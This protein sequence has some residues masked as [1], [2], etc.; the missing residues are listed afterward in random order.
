MWRIFVRP[1]T[2]LRVS[3]FVAT[4]ATAPFGVVDTET[5]AIG[6]TPAKAEEFYTRKRV[7]GRWI[8]GHFTRRHIAKS[9]RGVEPEARPVADRRFETEPVPTT[10]ASKAEPATERAIKP[11]PVFPAATA[12]VGR[13]A[14]SAEPAAPL[15]KDERLRELQEALHA[16]ARSLVANAESASAAPSVNGSL[17]RHQLSAASSEPKSVSFEFESGV[18]TTVFTDG[19]KVEEPF[20]P[21]SMKGLASARPVRSAGSRP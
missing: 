14:A 10:P 6:I 7:R 5:L 8:T 13:P 2:T 3:V 17:S 11:E 1:I 16:H 18:K 20:D 19:T 12:Q 4:L 15:T 21:A 9:R